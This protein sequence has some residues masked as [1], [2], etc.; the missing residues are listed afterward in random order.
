MK[1][2]QKES[3]I[4]GK[5]DASAAREELAAAIGFGTAQ[6]YTYNESEFMIQGILLEEIKRL[7][8]QRAQ[9]IDLVD[10]YLTVLQQEQEQTKTC[11]D[12]RS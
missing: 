5:F 3:S 11:V 7:R 12:G 9:L 4:K 2:F 10:N 8:Q 6:A 1:N